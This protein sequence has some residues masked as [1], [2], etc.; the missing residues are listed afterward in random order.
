MI[1]SENESSVFWIC[2]GITSLNAVVSLGFS[3]ARVLAPV[4]GEAALYAASRSM[5]LLLVILGLFWFRSKEGMA[6]LAIV[7]GLVQVF[8]TG[9]GLLAHAVG[10]TVGPLVFAVATFASAGFLLREME[11]CRL[12]SDKTN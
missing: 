6:A 1:P 10:K 7:M 8:D 9:I 4:G 5:A 12:E 3:A 11:K 2:A